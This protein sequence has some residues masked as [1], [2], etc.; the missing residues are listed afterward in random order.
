MPTSRKRARPP[1]LLI[2][3]N[4]ILDM[5]LAR[6]PWAADATLLLDAAAT[7]RA[8]GFIASHAVTTIHYIVSKATSR[9]VATRAIG[10]LLQIVRVVGLETDDFYQALTLGLPGFEDAAQVAAAMT[11]G[12][13]FIVTRNARDFRG[14]PIATQPPGAMLAILDAARDK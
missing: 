12:A 8:S 3:T 7:E 2:D 10:D 6:E 9:K 13:D 1:A 5:M 4:V 14:S 11:I